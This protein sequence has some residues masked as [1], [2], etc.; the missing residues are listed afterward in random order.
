MYADIFERKSQMNLL[1]FLNLD[2]QFYENIVIAEFAGKFLLISLNDLL[3]LN[4]CKK[5]VESLVMMNRLV[6]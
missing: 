1:I 6:V 2:R 5:W 4:Y 3:S